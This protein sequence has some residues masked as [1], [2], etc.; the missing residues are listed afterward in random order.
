MTGPRLP[1]AD[2][3]ISDG[4]ELERSGRFG[5]AAFRRYE[6]EV[7]YSTRGYRDLLL[8][9]SGHIALEQGAPEGPLDCIADLIDWRYE[10]RITKRY[11]TELRVATRTP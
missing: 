8:T 4:E 10:G 6:W 9:Y 5:S 2:E 11:L 1:P 3:I 7:G